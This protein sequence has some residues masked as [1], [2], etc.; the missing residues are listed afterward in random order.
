[1]MESEVRKEGLILDIKRDEEFSETWEEDERV[2]ANTN[3]LSWGKDAD[4]NAWTQP[5]QA[6]GSRPT[7]SGE[8]DLRSRGEK[9]D[10]TS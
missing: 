4:W 5:P 7:S 10:E 8:Q 1:M 2:G 6:H 9:K 3:M